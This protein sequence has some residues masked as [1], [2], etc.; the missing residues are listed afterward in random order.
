[1]AIGKV[2]EPEVEDVFLVEESI[3]EGLFSVV[4]EGCE[5]F[6]FLSHFLFHAAMNIE[7]PNSHGL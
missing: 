1:L 3:N 4:E 2:I 5:L 7:L 6:I